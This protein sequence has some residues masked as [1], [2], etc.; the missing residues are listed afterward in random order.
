MDKFSK[1]LLKEIGSGEVGCGHQQL[2]EWVDDSARK[3]SEL[4]AHITPTFQDIN[5]AKDA[6]KA[7]FSKRF[8]EAASV[9]ID[10]QFWA[11][12]GLV[13]KVVQ[14]AEGESGCKFLKRNTPPLLN[15]GWLAKAVASND[16]PR[17]TCGKAVD[18]RDIVGFLKRNPTFVP[19]RNAEDTAGG[20]LTDNECKQHQGN[21]DRSWI[22]LPKR[23]DWEC[24]DITI[25]SNGLTI[26]SNGLKRLS[27]LTVRAED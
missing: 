23:L 14:G 7:T 15:I 17:H 11:S 12:Q 26:V 8:V 9:P 25:V 13:V 6:V 4:N 10:Q 2:V 27:D 19:A 18:G 1:L 16:M 5:Q 24:E 3:L 21:I 20:T 22:V